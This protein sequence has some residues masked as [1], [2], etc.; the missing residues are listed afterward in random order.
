MSVKPTS[1]RVQLMRVLLDGADHTAPELIE[2][3]GISMSSTY[4]CLCRMTVDGWV[5]R[6]ALPGTGRRSFRVTDKG[7]RGMR[8]VT[9][10]AD[11]LDDDSRSSSP[12][13][14]RS[15]S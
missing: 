8:Y 2:L 5:E 7:I 11:Q 3:T 9:A 13:A 4:G 12:T 1:P 14:S 10:L 6:T 15:S